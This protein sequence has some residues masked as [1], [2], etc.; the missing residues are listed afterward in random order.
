[1][2][3]IGKVLMIAH[4]IPTEDSAPIA[5]RNCL[6]LDGNEFE[7][8]EGN[9]MIKAIIYQSE[10]GHSKEYADILGKR[11]GIPVYERKE[12]VAAIAKDTEAIYI[13]WLMAGKI[14]GYQ[15]A[16]KHFSIS[17]LCAV[18]M[19]GN[20]SQL[21]EIKKTNKL[22]EDL[23]VYYLQGGF[24]IEKLHG[25]YRFMMNT[26]KKTVGKMLTKKNDRTPEEDDMLEL[27]I[28][29]GNRVS[30]ENLSG[31]IDFISGVMK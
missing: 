22:P 7:A 17:A 8:M 11:T 1:M 24:E 4:E 26:M 23:P 15:N 3:G 12:A 25:L 21:A 28:N 16:M 9:H 30:E 19:S 6:S 13:G 14:V 2:P 20:D 31:I 18:G 5:E 27:L 29:G 10:T